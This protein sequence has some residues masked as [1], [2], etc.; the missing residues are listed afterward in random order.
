MLLDM[1]ISSTSHRDFPHFRRR[2]LRLLTTYAW[3]DGGEVLHH[4]G[5]SLA[6]ALQEADH[7]ISQSQ[8]SLISSGRQSYPP[9]DLIRA[10]AQ[11]YG[12]SPMYFFDERVEIEENARLD[13]RLASLRS[14][15]QQGGAGFPGF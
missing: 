3:I 15:V 9:A 1:A 14:I 10:L 8:V 2:W 4:S 11:V 6:K 5:K 7:P 13:A 12:V